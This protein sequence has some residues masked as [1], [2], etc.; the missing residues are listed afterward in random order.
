MKVNVI[1]AMEDVACPIGQVFTKIEETSIT[2]KTVTKQTKTSANVALLF[3]ITIIFV[4][5]W[6]PALLDNLEVPIPEGIQRLFIVNSVV[7]PFIY[8]IV[9]DKFRDDV[10][11]FYDQARVKLSACCQ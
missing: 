6:L 9:S 5:C 8:S 1:K 11:Q 7:N 10:R 3:I 2:N 4:F